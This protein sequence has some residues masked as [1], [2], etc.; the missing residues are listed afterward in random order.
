[1]ET[2][3]S[4]HAYLPSSDALVG[5][6]SFYH[7]MNQAIDILHQSF[8]TNSFTES[9]AHATTQPDELVEFWGV[10][11]AL[12]NSIHPS[13]LLS[14]SPAELESCTIGGLPLSSEPP[15]GPIDSF[16]APHWSS[17]SMV[18]PRDAKVCLCAVLKEY[19]I[20][21]ICL[22]P[23][24]ARSPQPQLNGLP[25]RMVNQKSMKEMLM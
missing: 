20:Q 4:E 23:R 1:M 5:D 17:V 18:S 21:A 24:S 8:Q 19:R 3:N 22:T 2:S 16:T 6:P 25:L 14:S 9:T 10:T 13:S 15:G 11:L 7:T 12:E